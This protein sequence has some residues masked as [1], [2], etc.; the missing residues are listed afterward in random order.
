[1]EESRAKLEVRLV[2]M[3][4]FF[5]S[6]FRQPTAFCVDPLRLVELSRRLRLRQELLDL[7]LCPLVSSAVARPALSSKVMVLVRQTPS[8]FFSA[9]F[10]ADSASSLLVDSLLLDRNG[11]SSFSK[12]IN[13]TRQFFQSADEADSFVPQQSVA[14][15]QGI[16]RFQSTEHFCLLLRCQNESGTTFP[17]VT[18]SSMFTKIR[19]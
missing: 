13:L 11:S 17:F 5:C 9:W 19:N 3:R 18:Q 7:F 12:V 16:Q 10:S 2:L 6:F 8:C 14:V 4:F 1:M 15:R